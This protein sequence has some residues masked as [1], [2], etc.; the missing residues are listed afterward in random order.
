[1]LFSSLSFL[2]FFLP[3]VILFYFIFPW[4][5]WKNAV[6]LVA[7]LLFYSWGDFNSLPLF[8]L[9][10]AAVWLCGIWIERLGEHNRCKKIIFIMAVTLLTGLLLYF[11]YLGFILGSVAS[12]TKVN[13]AFKS[14]IL[15]AGISFYT[16]QLLSYL[17]DLN[18]DKIKCEHNFFNFMLYVSFFP[19]L[20]QGPIVRYGNIAHELKNRSISWDDA[21]YGARRFIIGLGKKVLI[22][23]NIA[24][25][26]SGIYSSPEFS[27]TAA[28]WLAAVT[29]TLQL[30]FDFS[31]YCDMA[32]GLGRIFGFHLPENF[33]YPYAATSITDFWRRWHITL[34]LWFRDYIYIP[35]GGNRVKTYHF[36]LN[37]LA[38]WALTGL[39]H[40][41]SWNFVGWGIYYGILLLA[42]K[43]LLGEKIEA[44]PM[45]LRRVSTLFFVTL[46]WVLFNI[47]DTTVLLSTL[48]EMF[49]YSSTD[50][51]GLMRQDMSICSKLPMLLLAM[52]FSFPVSKQF[53]IRD[54]T[55]LSSIVI[56][57]GY[58]AMLAFCIMYIISSSFTPFIYFSF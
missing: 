43:L 6:L 53:H 4:D 36:V 7:S 13:I 5:K 48:R 3:L 32:I 24:L 56:N 8:F 2:Y 10:S 40:G 39:W 50:W 20:I 19:Q 37:L 21:I 41:A 9:S 34:S 1:M 49:I 22:A 25:I 38:V 47:S 45:L 14:T 33:N 16:F 26:V 27:G 35:L 29:Y 44:V 15:P 31:G 42:E 23:D 28:L 57:S 11:K 17:F 58:L 12:I 52:L 51:L 18:R 55:V 54:N 46:G 30:Y